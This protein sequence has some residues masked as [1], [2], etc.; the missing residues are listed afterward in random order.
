MKWAIVFV[1]LQ[2]LWGCFFEHWDFSIKRDLDTEIIIH[3][4]PLSIFI[5]EVKYGKKDFS[6]AVARFYFNPLS[7]TSQYLPNDW[8][9]VALLFCFQSLDLLSLCGFKMNYPFPL[10]NM[11]QLA[12]GETEPKPSS[13]LAT[14][15][16]GTADAY[17]VFLKIFSESDY[18][19]N[20]YQSA[21]IT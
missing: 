6:E 10:P 8:R 4:P 19:T 13:S 21:R 5:A 7:Y 14:N 17:A 9:K 11:H 2:H 3:Y 1:T 16:F 18:C 12:D 20:F 15:P